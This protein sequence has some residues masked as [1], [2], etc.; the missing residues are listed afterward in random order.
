M[1][2]ISIENEQFKENVRHGTTN[3]P[4]QIYQN[5]ENY[6]KNLIFYNHWHEEAEI[7]YIN[8]GE[9]EVVVDGVSIFA[10]KIQ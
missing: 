6:E 3:F 9:M 2:N 4:L 8:S 7:L 10:K 5:I 1:K